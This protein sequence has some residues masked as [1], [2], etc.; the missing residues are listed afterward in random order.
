MIDK[1]RH[2]DFHTRVPQGRRFIQEKGNVMEKRSLV[3]LI[4]GA[5]LMAGT[6]GAA[7]AEITITCGVAGTE[8]DLCK[9]GAEAW[10]K[11]TGNTIR[12]LRNV[13]DAS[14]L[15]GL[16]Q[17]QLTSKSGEVDVYMLN[18]IWPGALAG[19]FI[20]LKP[21]T[22]GS[23]AEHYPN[24]LADYLVDGKLVGLPWY[25]DVGV[26]YYRKDL[27]EKYGKQVPKTW[28]ELT[29]TAQS[30][31]D[32]EHAAGN[33][34]LWGYVF[35]GKAYEGL[36]CN[37]IEWIDAFGGGTVIDRKGKITVNNA[38]AAKALSL[39]ASWVGKI[40][41][42]G[43]LGYAEEETRGIFQTGNAVFLRNW[44][45]V[46]ALAS[47]DDSP[48]KGKFGV[49]ALPRGDVEGGKPTGNIGG[50]GLGVSEYS[51]NKELAVDLVLYLTGAAEQ[52]RR[53]ISNS[54]LP[55]R[56]ALFEDAD[57]LKAVPLFASIGPIVQNGVAL[58][59]TVTGAKYNQVSAAFW[60]SVHSVLEG[61]E[62]PED[63][64]PELEATLSKIG[65]GGW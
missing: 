63:A 19:H 15:Y 49:A 29:Q 58:P 31:M 37:A 22:K 14:E 59:S 9:S 28:E 10:A 41:P 36:S 27:L 34:K 57:I 8:F 17:Q 2:Y 61:S 46:W 52:K 5:L 20:D 30:I 32:A 11:K 55:T 24:V 56:P 18:N 38:N 44:P 51:G 16:F 43:V 7:A 6:G 4:L 42:E 39:A 48:I 45:Y 50:W 62:T 53:A 54:F 21:Y 26:L 25:N 35:Q 1:C 13:E 64:L 65:R 33:D 12:A 40:S 23:E 47:S 60:E 3:G